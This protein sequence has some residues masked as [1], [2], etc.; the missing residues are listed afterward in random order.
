HRDFPTRLLA[1]SPSGGASVHHQDR[2]FMTQLTL[3][4]PRPVVCSG[5]WPSISYG[6]ARSSTV[7][8]PCLD[9]LSSLFDLRAPPPDRPIAHFRGRD[10]RTRQAAPLHNTP[11]AVLKSP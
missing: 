9:R 6:S 5:G 2:H 11:L 3:Q 7:L 8:A 10:Q 4:S 1:T